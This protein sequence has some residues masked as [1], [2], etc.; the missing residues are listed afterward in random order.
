[1][2]T[3]ITTLEQV[4]KSNEGKDFSVHSSPSTTIQIIQ[5][6]CRQK[7]HLSSHTLPVSDFQVDAS[8]A[9]IHGVARTLGLSLVLKSRPLAWDGYGNFVLRNLAQAEG[10]IAALGNRPL[11]AE[12]W[13]NVCHLV[14]AP[15]RPEA[16]VKSLSGA[17]VFSVEMFLMQV[18]QY[19]IEACE[20]SQY[21]NYLPA[22]L[23]LPPGPEYCFCSHAQSDRTF[24]FYDGV[25]NHDKHPGDSIHLYGKSEC[26][27]SRKMRHIT[28]VADPNAQLKAWLRPLLESLPSSSSEE[29]DLYAPLSATP[30]FSDPNPLVGVWSD[31]DLPAMLP[32]ARILNR[33][34]IPHGRAMAT[35]PVIGVPIKGS[36]LDGV[37]SL[38]SIAQMP[39]RITIRQTISM[40]LPRLGALALA[41]TDILEIYGKYLLSYGISNTQF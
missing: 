16:V 33:S 36:A 13:D 15:L 5:D 37:D 41:S 9:A 31:S 2:S 6:K 19:T 26:R 20:A 29:T 4:Q 21:E 32:A 28:V 40:E 14:F 24:V 17:G 30:G 34:K 11:Y 1:M 10:V 39:M 27:S 35:L 25:N 18:R 38:H 8:I 12:K 3:L 7:Q 22:I 23:S